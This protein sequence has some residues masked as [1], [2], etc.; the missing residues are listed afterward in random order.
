MSDDEKLSE[1]VDF[2]SIFDLELDVKE[3]TEKLEELLNGYHLGMVERMKIIRQKIQ[4]FKDAKRRPIGWK[5][6]Q[7]EN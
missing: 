4:A 6:A 2:D 3:Y 1:K 7:D 5:K